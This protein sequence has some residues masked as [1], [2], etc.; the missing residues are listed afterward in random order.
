MDS[1]SGHGRTSQIRCTE[2]YI[3][4]FQ[5]GPF[6]FENLMN[7]HNQQPFVKELACYPVVMMNGKERKELERGGKSKK[8]CCF[9]VSLETRNYFNLN[10]IAF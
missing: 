4:L 9:K 10:V 1:A 8:A 6:R 5:L 2:S 3:C 7:M